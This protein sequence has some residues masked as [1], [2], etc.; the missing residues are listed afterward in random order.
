[1]FPKRRMRRA[2]SRNIQPLLREITLTKN[3]LVAPLFV[4]EMIAIPRPIDT[5]PGQSRY[6]VSGIG[7]AAQDLWKKGVRAVPAVRDP[8]RERPGRSGP[9]QTRK[10]WSSRRS[11]G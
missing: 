4:D 1:M 6:P 11:G 7:G 5:M 8:E 9:R 3:D 10:G 2:R